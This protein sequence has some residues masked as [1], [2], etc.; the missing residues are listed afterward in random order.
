MLKDSPRVRP[1]SYIH[2]WDQI[3][4]YW[5]HIPAVTPK[6]CCSFIFQF[7]HVI[8]NYE[9]N[10][11]DLNSKTRVAYELG[12]L[13]VNQN[14][15]CKKKEKKEKCNKKNLYLMPWP[16]RFDSEHHYVSEFAFHANRFSK[17]G[18]SLLMA[19]PIKLKTHPNTN[20][21]WCFGFVTSSPLSS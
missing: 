21:Y 3:P 15:G 8:L 17:P 1:Y 9:T 19:V 18:S 11:D 10:Q 12:H 20:I 16:G 2:K 6:M 4:L 14:R 5:N 7:L 13:V